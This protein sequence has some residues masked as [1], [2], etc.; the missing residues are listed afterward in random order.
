MRPTILFFVHAWGGGAIRAVRELAAYL[1]PRVNVVY[2]WGV[3]ERTF[4]ISTRDPEH[5]E[6]SFDLANGL[7]EPLRALKALDISRVDVLCTVGSLSYIDELL[8]RLDVPFDV[9]HLGY[10]LIALDR[11]Q[12][13][14]RGRYLGDEALLALAGKVRRYQRL[15]DAMRAFG[16]QSRHR[17]AAQVVAALNAGD[18]AVDRDGSFYQV[19]T[20]LPTICL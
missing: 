7:D 14:T 9:T 1:S 18:V 10:E 12:M 16:T 20:P 5:A 11:Q 13:D 17:Q 4:H 6:Q 2:A 8:D 15:R 19:H 3:K